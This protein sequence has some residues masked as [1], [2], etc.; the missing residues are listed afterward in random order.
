MDDTIA[1]IAT[2]YGEAAI[3][4]VRVSGKNAGEV[5]AR[6][7]K[8]RS[9]KTPAE[10]QP[11]RLY[12]AEVWDPLEKE[13]IDE[14]LA[15]IMP[16]PRSYTGETVVEIHGHGGLLVS[17]AVLQAVLRAG[18]RLAEPGE[19][20]KRAF[21]NGKKDLS[22]AEAVID[23]IRARGE[24]ARRLA[25]RRMEGKLYEKIS[26]LQKQLTGLI[27]ALEAGIDFPDE[28]GEGEEWLPRLEEILRP[29][30]IL[31]DGARGGRAAREG[32][33]VV[34][35]GSP[36][37][38]K[39]SLWNALIGEEKA[40]V[41]EIPGTT[42]DALEEVLTVRGVPIRLVDT[43]GIRETVDLVEQLGVE[44][45]REML[46]R[47]DLTI[48]VFDA[49]AGISEEDRVVID[50]VAGLNRLIVVNKTDLEQ[51]IDEKQILDYFPKE[52]IFWASVKEGRGIEEIKEAVLEKVAG[53]APE[54]SE[55]LI[56]NQ[57]QENAL[58]RAMASLAAARTA[59]EERLPLE[60]VLIDLREGWEAL[61]E[62]TGETVNEQIIDRI[63]E[64]FCI[65]K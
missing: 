21:L 13:K 52:K 50:L 49:A 2:P 42:R 24:A 15:V 27:A 57:R 34:I 63:F 19:F 14:V 26:G 62:I 23:L 59:A 10:W 29:G 40:I 45:T 1:A 12:L 3:A 47:G 44:R 6:I 54:E 43:A 58:E 39:S 25:L 53:D 32:I 60:C 46:R 11:H 38:G 30:K 18:A 17:R 20:T 16:A 48:V 41:T 22:Q 5:A 64:D 33:R 28:L 65:G 4:V 35:V 8:G 51:H 55:W 56:S 61:G 31:L 9:G 37:V 36:N 7:L